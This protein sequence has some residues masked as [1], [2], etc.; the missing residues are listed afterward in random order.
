MHAYSDSQTAE[1]A[2][3]AVGARAKNQE[4]RV[5]EVAGAAGA[6]ETRPALTS[7]GPSPP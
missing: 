4:A 5:P 3:A 6:P 7:A 2:V 1:D